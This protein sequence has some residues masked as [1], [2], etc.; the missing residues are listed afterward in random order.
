MIC[1]LLP[2]TPSIEIESARCVPVICES[3]EAV[4]LAAKS[5]AVNC[6]PGKM[7]VA[8]ARPLR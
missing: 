5:T 2:W 6:W 4:S 3:T 1:E 7:S 8:A